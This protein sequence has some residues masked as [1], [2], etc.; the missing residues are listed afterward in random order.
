MRRIKT[1]IMMTLMLVLLWGLQAQAG[2][3][4]W[5]DDSVSGSNL[6]LDMSLEVQV[7]NEPRFDYGQRK[8]I[9]FRIK[10]R[11]GMSSEGIKDVKF[12]PITANDSVTYPFEITNQ[13][14]SIPDIP[15]NSKE[16]VSTDI[17]L[18]ARNDV[19]SGYRTIGYQIYF[20]YAGKQYY[21]QDEFHV[22]INGNPDY[23]NS[24]SMEETT[25]SDPSE[26]NDIKIF[27][28]VNQSTP[29]CVYGQPVEITLTLL[30]NGGNTANGVVITPVVDADSNVFPFEIQQMDY[31]RN[32]ETLIGTGYQND[33]AARMK[34]VTYS[35]VTRQKVTSGY[36]KVS[37]QIDYYTDALIDKT[38]TKDIYVMVQ[39][40]PEMDEEAETGENGESKTSIPRVIVSGYTTKPKDILA[41]DSFEIT[42]QKT[43][44]SKQT[45]VSNMVFDIQ[46]ENFTIDTTSNATA[47]AFLPVSGSS[48]IF[49]DRI[50]PEETKEISIEMTARTDLSP[51]P[52]V[53]NVKMDYEDGKKNT[54]ESTA[55]VSVP[56]KQKDKMEISSPEIMPES[57]DVGGQAN[58][59]FSIY[60]TGKTQLYN[61]MVRFKGDSIEETECFVGNVAAGATGSV[62]TMLTGIAATMDDGT[63]IAEITYENQSG[64][65][66]TVE[67]EYT[68][69]VNEFMPG[70]DIFVDG[71]MG[72]GEMEEPKSNNLPLMIG[73]IV[74]VLAA[75]GA[76]AF[77][78]IKKK[79]AKL[80]DLLEGEDIDEV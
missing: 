48:S 68:L 59:M 15:A 3:I 79:K 62:D 40:N 56:V 67:K 42:L 33:P 44:T 74:A 41:G 26:K 38:I 2:S 71:D 52:Y 24:G 21:Y 58:I 63:L 69:F 11:N 64:E 73:G 22:N 20:K 76:A 51:R 37:F 77:V 49:V 80:Q 54:Y 46:S 70:D 36:K 34:T 39:G 10:F 45:A 53:L 14:I 35:W 8:N 72:M 66:L 16:Y 6:E 17:S 23:D 57:I 55:S 43:N 5:V 31:S 1:G 78:I 12:H 30:N 50:G 27:M 18:K 75:G 32:L 28:G 13:D 60:N 7:E 47:A 4:V 25:T 19:L 65:S 61:V 9:N 29:V